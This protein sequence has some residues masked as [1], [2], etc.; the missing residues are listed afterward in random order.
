M[1]VNIH[2]KDAKDAKES[3]SAEAVTVEYD[4]PDYTL[5][6]C[7]MH[8]RRYFIKAE[9][10]EPAAAF[11][12]N[13]IDQLFR[14][15]QQANQEAG[16]EPAD[17]KRPTPALLEARR[18]LRDTESRK[19][20]EQLDGWRRRRASEPGSALDKAVAHLNRTWTRAVRFLEDPT[21]PIDNG[22]VE[23][24]IRP[25]VLM[26]NSSQGFRSPDGALVAGVLLTLLWTAVLTGVEPKAYLVALVRQAMA[27][28]SVVY[29]P[30]MHQEVLEAEAQAEAPGGA[31]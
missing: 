17:G 14:I 28:P 29:T 19:V 12:L 13:L 22:L 9:K 10:H 23:R 6:T 7:W 21:L 30:Q 27:D 24:L 1:E 18:R 15:E 5:V 31:E 8:I 26:R 16:F 4:L 2:A 25:Q 20:I 3:D 11:P